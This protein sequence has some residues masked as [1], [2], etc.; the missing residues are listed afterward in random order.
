MSRA[1]L[2]ASVTAF[3]ESITALANSEDCKSLGR[4][5]HTLADVQARIAKLQAQEA[6]CEFFDLTEIVDDYLALLGS[7]R[8]RAC[9]RTLF[10]LL[11]VGN[12]ILLFVL[13]CVCVTV[14]VNVRDSACAC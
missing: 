4:A 13:V 5:L 10:F 9:T 11:V 3:V 6:L 12:V 2:S 1:D 14:Y 7:V 8:V